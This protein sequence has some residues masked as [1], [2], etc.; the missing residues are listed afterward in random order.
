MRQPSCRLHLRKLSAVTL[1]SAISRA[2]EWP[3]ARKLPKQVALHDQSG[4][5]GGHLAGKSRAGEKTVIHYA[6][7]R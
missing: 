7:S 3:S 6:A 2:Q 4:R 5:K 1:S